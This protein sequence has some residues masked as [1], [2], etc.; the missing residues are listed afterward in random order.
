MRNIILYSTHCPKCRMLEAQLRKKGINFELVTDVDVM[1]KKGMSS[2]PML[3]VDGELKDYVK[4][5]KWIM[6]EN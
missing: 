5:T 1:L 6:E 4:A 3:E 2:A